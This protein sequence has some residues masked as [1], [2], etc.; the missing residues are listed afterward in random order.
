MAAEVYLTNARTKHEHNL[1]IKTEKL[2]KAA[3]FRNLIKENDLVAIKAHFSEPGNTA[4]L[5][6]QFARR[7]VSLVKAAG[8]K[9]FLTDANTLYTGRRGNAVDH[10]EAAIEN[11]FAYSVVNAPLIIADGLTGKDFVEVAVE[12]KHFQF[13]KISSSAY[14]AD[15]LISLTH[16]RGHEATGFGGTIKN[17]GMGL[18]SRSGKQMMHI[19]LLPTVNIEKCTGCGKC[20]IWCPAQAITLLT[21]NPKKYAV[22][23]QKKCIGCGECAVTCSPGAIAIGWEEEEHVLQEKMAEFALGIIKNKNGK[24]A[25]FNFLLDITPDCDCASWSDLPIVNDIGI[26]ASKDPVAID[27]AGVDLVNQQE[28]LAGTRLEEKIERGRDKF[29]AVH[30]DIDWTV[31]LAYAEKIGLGTREYK[32][33]TV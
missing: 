12:Q 19:G 22:I 29:R 15:V 5:R 7:V 9:P 28:G 3:G 23:N 4:Y 20:V 18:G 13:V 33:V 16:F 30:K 6:P 11:G 32:L 24:V 21:R 14:H 25:F 17:V 1:L 27:Q 26:L 31:Q 8:G 2:F 10:L